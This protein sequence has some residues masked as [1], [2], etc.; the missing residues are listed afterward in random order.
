V[1]HNF[2]TYQ[3]QR[4]RILLGWGLGSTLIGLPLII[5][6]S[7]FWRSFGLQATSWGLIDALLAIF[8]IA[9]AQRK[10]T[11]TE[12]GELGEEEALAEARSFRRILLINAGLD[13]LYIGGGITTARRAAGRP[14]RQGMGLGIAA[15]GLFLLIFDS[16]LAREV[17]EHWL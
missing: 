3:R 9:G 11:R 12:V 2:F 1:N 17:G 14:D 6:P 16:L 10:A 4:L 5:S 8:G 15:Q 13:L 7:P